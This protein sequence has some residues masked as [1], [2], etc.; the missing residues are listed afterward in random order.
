MTTQ[1]FIGCTFR[2]NYL[3][4]RKK[5]FCC[6]N[7]HSYISISPGFLLLVFLLSLLFADQNLP[8]PFYKLILYKGLYPNLIF[9]CATFHDTHPPVDSKSKHYFRIILQ[10]LQS[11]EGLEQNLEKFNVTFK[12]RFFSLYICFY[13]IIYSYSLEVTKK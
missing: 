3:G 10:W 4:K 9:F 13:L 2:T 8:L 7:K 11:A 6:C 5:Q 12:Q 1:V